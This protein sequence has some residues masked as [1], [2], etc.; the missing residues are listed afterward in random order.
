MSHRLFVLV[1]IVTSAA[2]I[3]QLI[4]NV[5]TYLLIIY[6]FLPQRL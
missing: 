5:L 2:G 1:V 6:M 4:I 3:D